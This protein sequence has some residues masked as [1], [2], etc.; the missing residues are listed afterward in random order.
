MGDNTVGEF[1]KG[2][3]QQLTAAFNP[4]QEDVLLS[5]IKRLAAQTKLFD[6][7]RKSFTESGYAKD[8]EF[9]GSAFSAAAEKSLELFGNTNRAKDALDAFRTNSKAFVYM[10]DGFRASLLK[11]SVAMQGLGFEAA[12]LAEI[13]D[14]G[15]YAFGSSAEELKGLMADFTQMSQNL[16]IPGDTLAKNFRSAQQNFAYNTKVFKQN[17]KDLQVMARQTGLSFDSLTSTFGS[18]FDSFEGAAQKAGQLNQILGKSAFNSIEMLNATEAER[19]A[20]VKKE[21]KGRDPSKMGKFELLA[22]KDTLGFGSVEETR[23]FLKTGSPGG[24]GTLDEKKYGKLKTSMKD[25][26][27]AIKVELTDLADAIRR[28]RS[29]IENAMVALGTMMQEQT[30]G[31]GTKPLATA[32]KAKYGTT[33]AEANKIDKALKDRWAGLSAMQK[34]YVSQLVLMQK[35]VASALAVLKKIDPSSATGLKKRSEIGITGKDIFPGIS[36]FIEKN[37]GDTKKMIAAVTTIVAASKVAGAIEGFTGIPKALTTL[38]ALEELA[39]KVNTITDKD[40]EKLRKGFEGAKKTFDLILEQLG[41]Y[42]PNNPVV[43]SALKSS[44]VGTPKVP[45]TGPGK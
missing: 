6:D 45:A 11:T 18:S 4:T 39:K 28:G 21:F 31:M 25:P 32:I 36:E 19:A 44:N 24:E 8:I 1:T 7:Q 27:D 17:F 9:L 40:I 15:M 38:G 2:Q 23:K 20:K 41:V 42:A 37:K 10:Q 43:R 13:V 5:P 16:A 33:A 29:P 35:D 14:S 34:A 22:I 12:T 30:A 3:M 26:S